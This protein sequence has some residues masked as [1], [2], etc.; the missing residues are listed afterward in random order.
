MG[1]ASYYGHYLT[2]AWPSMGHGILWAWPSLG[3]TCPGSTLLPCSGRVTARS[4]VLGRDAAAGDAPPPP[5]SAAG[6]STVCR[7][8]SAASVGI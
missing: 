1:M 3:R 8:C 2:G 4:C 7:A 5:S 6:E